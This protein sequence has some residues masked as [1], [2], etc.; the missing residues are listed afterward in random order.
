VDL[1]PSTELVALL[2]LARRK[3]GGRPPPRN[4]A[5]LQGVLWALARRQRRR[6]VVRGVA[7]CAA[8]A[9]LSVLVLNL[10]RAVEE[11]R[12][13]A[14]PERPRRLFSLTREDF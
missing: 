10:A 5:R 3:L 6:R 12:E 14:A 4:A 7:V 2:A 11:S 13:G 8:V 9:A 1:E